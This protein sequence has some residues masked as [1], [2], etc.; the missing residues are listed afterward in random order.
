MGPVEARVHGL[1]CPVGVGGLPVNFLAHVSQN[2]HF[3]LQILRKL[4]V[5]LL[6]HRPLVGREELC[7]GTASF[8]GDGRDSGAGARASAGTMGAAMD[9]AAAVGTAAGAAAG[10][11][12]GAASPSAATVRASV[13]VEGASLVKASRAPLAQAAARALPAAAA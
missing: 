3:C 13:C 5:P 1:E 10:G 4:V 12:A 2:C 7:S 9:A 8:C 6:Q 11:A